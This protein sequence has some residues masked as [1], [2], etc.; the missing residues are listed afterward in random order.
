[1]RVPLPEILRNSLFTAGSGWSVVPN[2]C[3]WHGNGKPCQ[4]K[5]GLKQSNSKDQRLQ[6]R[7]DLSQLLGLACC[8]PWVFARVWVAI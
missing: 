7:Y 1:M 6:K 3:R 2:S 8:S 5:P 4:G